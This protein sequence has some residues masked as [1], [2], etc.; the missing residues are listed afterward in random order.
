MQNKKQEIEH[1]KHNNKESIVEEFVERIDQILNDAVQT[2]KVGQFSKEE[3]ATIIKEILKK[4]L[5]ELAKR[6]IEEALKRATEPKQEAKGEAKVI[7][8]SCEFSET[9]IVRGIGK[10]SDWYWWNVNEDQKE[11]GKIAL[12]YEACE[13][14]KKAASTELADITKTLKC[15]SPCTPFVQIDGPKITHSE[16]HEDPDWLTTELICTCEAEA[17]IIYGCKKS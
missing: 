11:K 5:E 14:A 15:D 16:C 4:I 1:P 2:K 3:R 8:P 9:R 13:V 7:R 10:A 17:T 6:G 12:Q